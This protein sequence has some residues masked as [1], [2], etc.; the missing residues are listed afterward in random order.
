M[1]LSGGGLTTLLT[2]FRH[3]AFIGLGTNGGWVQVGELATGSGM[4][5]MFGVKP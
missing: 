2:G 1:P 4:G 3:E 5:R